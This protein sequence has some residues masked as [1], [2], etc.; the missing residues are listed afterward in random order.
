MRQYLFDNMIDIKSLVVR[1][2]VANVTKKKTRLHI[3][4]NIH[5]Y[6]D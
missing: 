1:K 4:M 5:L 2:A 6:N 3:F